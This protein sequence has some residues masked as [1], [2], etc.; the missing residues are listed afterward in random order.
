MT[1]ERHLVV[2]GH[3]MAAHHLVTRLREGDATDAWRVTVLAE[4]GH[5][6]YD[7]VN[8]SAYLAPGGGP[9]SAGPPALPGRDPRED[10]AVELRLNTTVTAIDRRARTV[11]TGSGGRVPYDVLVLAT[12]SRPAVPPVPGH[13]LPG[14]HVYRTIADLDAIRATAARAAAGAPGAAAGVVVGGGLLGLEAANALRLLG[15]RP[16]VVE[17]AAWPM[18]VQLDEGGGRVL[19]RLVGELDVRLHCGA[20]VRSVD[21]GPDGRVAGVTLADGTALAAGVVIFATGVRPRDELAG[22]AGLATAERGGFL[23]DEHCRTRDGRIWAIGECAAV[24]GTTY[25]LVAPGYRMAE[26]VADRL[27][28]LEARP[29]PGADLSTRLKL[30]GVE[31]ASF[32]DAHARTPGAMEFAY[33]GGDGRRYAKLVLDESGRVLLGG[34]LAGDAAAYGTLRSLLG[35]PLTAPPE[36]YL[37]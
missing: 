36:H 6:A 2:V 18:P 23:V 21:A 37:C 25:G 14:C 7:R 8:L 28:G 30:L 13:D 9:G 33:A 20:G 22:P 19:G 27:L 34:V 5:P 26:L 16:H 10:P 32:G 15:L 1:G 17:L 24:R 35:R 12:G 3:G 31:V 4:E 29:F 11:V